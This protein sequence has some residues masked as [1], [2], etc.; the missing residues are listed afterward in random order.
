MMQK[1]NETFQANSRLLF[2]F[3]DYPSI[4]YSRKNFVGIP[5]IYVPDMALAMGP[6][7]PNASPVVDIVLLLRT[8]KENI[9]AKDD[10][11]AGLKMLETSNVTFEVWDFPVGGFPIKMM[12]DNKT[13]VYNY[14]QIYPKQ[15]S[16]LRANNRQAQLG[17]RIQMANNLFS[18]GRVVV[19]DRLHA[20]IMS[21]LMGKPLVYLDNSYKKITNVR[22]ALAKEFPECSDTNLHARH[23]STLLEATTLALAILDGSVKI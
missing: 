10:R 17:L 5:T 11:I 21:T 9:L 15:L 2:M 23:T 3:R 13:A 8:D 7:T 19:T 20:S 1:D 22:G 16:K 14:T 12:P 18:R 4:E 6:Q